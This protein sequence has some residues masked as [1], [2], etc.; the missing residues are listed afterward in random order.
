MSATV[1]RE[2]R[3]TGK[4]AWSSFVGFIKS[5]AKAFLDRGSPLRVI[6]TSSERIR[7]TEANARY[8]AILGEI[9]AQAWVNG[10]QFSKE[11]WHEFFARMYLPMEDVILPDGEI[12]QR[13]ITTTKLKVGEFGDYMTKVE[14]YAASELGIEVMS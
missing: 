8:W 9:S 2:F 13:R 3:M 5:N 7:S 1:Y 11:V 14:A 4:G 12:I 6:V 10:Q